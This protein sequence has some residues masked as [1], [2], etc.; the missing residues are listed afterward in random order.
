MHAFNWKTLVNVSLTMRKMVLNT[1]KHDIFCVI[2][3]ANTGNHYIFLHL[4]TLIFQEN[5]CFQPLTPVNALL[6]IRK[7][8]MNKR[9]TSCLRCVNQAVN[10]GKWF[11]YLLLP[12]ISNCIPIFLQE[13]SKGQFLLSC[14]K[15][16][17]N[18]LKS[19]ALMDK[20][21]HCHWQPW[22]AKT[23]ASRTVMCMTTAFFQILTK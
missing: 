2:Q 3:T 9:K 11:V 7:M 15:F 18:S 20:K 13:S 22:K 14:I 10:A 6:Y 5:A 16:Q 4:K 17:R 21:Q 8:L 19:L 1:R 23:P 12:Q